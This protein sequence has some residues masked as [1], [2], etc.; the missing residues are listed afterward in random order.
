MDSRHQQ[1][2][3]ATAATQPL[4]TQNDFS[5]IP[6][7]ISWLA[8]VVVVL[9]V[10]AK[11]AMKLNMVRKLALDDSCILLSLAFSIGMTA[12]VITAC[13]NG[14][15]KRQSGLSD[16]ELQIYQKAVYAARLMYILTLAFS[17]ASVLVLLGTISSNAT[18]RVLVYATGIFLS[19]WA[20]TSVLVSAF[21]CG[22]PRPWAVSSG[23]IQQCV[24]IVFACVPY[25]KQFFL[26]L[27]SGMIRVDDARR[28]ERTSSTWRRGA[29]SRTPD[30]SKGSTLESRELA[31][32]QPAA[33][34]WAG[35]NVSSARGGLEDGDADSIRSTARII[36]AT[37]TF[38]VHRENVKDGDSGA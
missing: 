21:V 11:L 31:E 34:S 33:G 4:V 8:A 13:H 3:E 9:C 28:R 36:R 17:K 35:V 18:H 32:L 15:G 38:E 24:S 2:E 37:R 12:G 29:R 16:R 25:L 19:L 7:V 22:L 20:L 1:M 26:S 30:R 23:C 5:S 10:A 6:I 27:E 14:L